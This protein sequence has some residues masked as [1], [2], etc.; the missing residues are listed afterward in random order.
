MPKITEGQRAES[1][2]KHLHSDI[3]RTNPSWLNSDNIRRFW[4]CLIF[5]LFIQGK[6]GVAS[7]AFLFDDD[8][9]VQS[10][11]R[12]DIINTPLHLRGS[13]TQPFP[14]ISKSVIDFGDITLPFLSS[15]A[16]ELIRHSRD[17]KWNV[18]CPSLLGVMLE[19]VTD[20][21][22]RH[23]SGMHYTNT[24]NTKKLI[25][26]LFM[27]GLTNTYKKAL[28]NKSDKRKINALLKLRLRIGAIKIFDP[29]CGNIL[30]SA[31]RSLRN[32]EFLIS[33]ALKTLGEPH[34]S[35]FPFVTPNNF[36]GVEY[37]ACAADVAKKALIITEL[38]LTNEKD[39][40][41]NAFES[42]SSG[43][44]IHVGSALQVPW[45]DVCR[46]KQDEEVVICGNPPYLGFNARSAE[47]QQEHARVMKGVHSSV[48]QLD[49][50]CNWF[51]LAAQYI[52][53]RYKCKYAFV[54]TNS[55]NQGVHVPRLWPFIFK[56]GLEINFAHIGIKWE[57]DANN[58]AAVDCAIVGLRKVSSSV[59]FIHNGEIQTEAENINPYLCLL[60][61]SDAA[62]E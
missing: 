7:S 6:E 12:F 46:A 29:A 23:Q 35:L 28:T 54:T 11:L 21:K 2:L 31:Y 15:N 18:V 58:Q 39:E 5:H 34:S 41:V 17:I 62:D 61:T 40:Q 55:V 53:T 37:D 19:N 22:N 44:N 60:Y 16:I 36:Y 8:E 25:D 42:P 3:I 59:K 30:I 1:L 33:D 49:Y 27:N 4:S 45:G 38:Q 20:S 51:V 50:V 56:L 24:K 57:S 52:S 26:S 10:R 14:Y 47:Q 9:H 48:N 32:M 13:I 43:P